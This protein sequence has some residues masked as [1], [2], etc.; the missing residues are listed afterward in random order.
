MK[1][2]LI[3]TEGGLN[4]GLGNFYRCLSLCR[5]VSKR[6]DGKISF[7][8]SSPESVCEL[9]K[10]AGLEI[11]RCEKE[12]VAEEII[13]IRPELLLIDVLGIGRE[14]TSKIRKAGIDIAIVGNDTDANRDAALVVNAI[15]GTGLGNRAFT[16]EFGT[17]NL[18]GPEYLVLRDEFEA[19]RDTYRHRGGIRSIVLLFGGSDQSDFTSKTLR[20]LGGKGYDISVI[21]GKAYPFLEELRS[22]AGEDTKV[23]CNIS[24]VSEI[25][26]SA[27]FLFTS[28]GT[29]LF[30]GLCLGIPSISFY[31]NESQ[32]E[33]FG[34]FFTCREFDS[35]QDPE[36]L[37]KKVYAGYEGFERERRSYNVGGG[38]D[39][40]VTETIKL[41]E[42]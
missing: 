37:M 4:L 6:W 33:V 39:R 9:V 42:K 19:L 34:D 12:K 15:I 18:W 40:I 28:P 13:S 41:L 7:I 20:R 32:K 24:N 16:D 30:E 38:R 14:F 10:A 3:Y 21:V 22:I 5:A 27:D 1:H 29:A 35:V 25:F 23:Y 17:L 11:R 26:R 31:Q 2:L 36:M 8:S